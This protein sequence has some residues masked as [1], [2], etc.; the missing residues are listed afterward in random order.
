MSWIIKMY[1]IIY[2]IGIGSWLFP[3]AGEIQF[4]QRRWWFLLAERRIR[5]C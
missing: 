4:F 5:S 2:I 3:M 1:M